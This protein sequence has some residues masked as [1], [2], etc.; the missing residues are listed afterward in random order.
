MP[1][2]L[3][4]K[5]VPGSVLPGESAAEIAE[6]ISAYYADPLGFVRACY[7]W[8]VAHTPLAN[9]SGPDENQAAFLRDLGREVGRRAFDGTTPVEP[10][11]MAENSGHGTGKS[12]MG[13][14]ITDWILSTRP[15]SIGTVTA[16]TYTQLESRTWAAIRQWTELCATRHWF[17]VRA[18]RIFHRAYPT[19]W[20]V[21]AQTARPENAQSFAGQHARTST[22]WYLFD[23]ASEIQDEVWRV[24]F[25]GLTD[26]EP[27]FFAWGQ[28]TRRSGKFFEICFGQ[29]RNRWIQRS[30]DSRTSRF[31]NKELI[32]Q[33]ID[34]YGIDSDFVRVR[35]LGQPPNVGDFQF[36]DSQRVLEA[37]RREPRFLPDDPLIAGVDVA[38][39]GGDWNV[40]R[41]RK[42]YDAV[43]IPPI[44]IPGEQTRDSTLLVSKLAELLSDRRPDRT[45]THMFV[46]AALGGP[47]VDR[48][49][50]LGYRNV[51]EINFGAASPDLHQANQRAYMW[52]R[53][54]DWL[55]Q[56]AIGKD[57]RLETDLTSL[58]FHHNQRDQLVLE[59]KEDLAKR[60]LPSPDDGDALALTFARPVAPV[61]PK[62]RPPRT[63]YTSP[64][65]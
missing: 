54:K 19:D 48:L 32:Q 27:M 37:Q 20:K 65:S 2:Q 33:W 7:P 59:S 15:H 43:T 4:S 30:V 56:G 8:G 41:Y 3:H 39:G 51:S 42:G 61:T 50:Q 24:A 49:R 36:I 14:W 35:V 44:R 1:S 9:E 64:W 13:A 22:S 21:V 11:R 17:E 16:G 63:A 55:L 52:Q 58:G 47:V 46:D 57:S 25:G 10:I 12:A 53:M 31:T 26:G 62:P 6:L 29:E 40:I 5:R 18:D 60:G 45:I 28:P 38:R 34:D 23:E